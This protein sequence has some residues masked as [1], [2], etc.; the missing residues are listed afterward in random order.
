MLIGFIYRSAK[1]CHVRTE[2][3][4]DVERLI[5]TWK[6]TLVASWSGLLYVLTKYTPVIW[7]SKSQAVEITAKQS[8]SCVENTPTSREWES[9][10]P[11]PTTSLLVRKRLATKVWHER[12]N[13]SLV[14]IVNEGRKVTRPAK[15]KPLRQ[16][17]WLSGVRSCALFSADV[18]WRRPRHHK[19]SVPVR[20]LT[21]GRAP[22]R[23]STF[24]ASDVSGRHS[25]GRS[26]R[27]WPMIR[28]C[29]WITSVTFYCHRVRLFVL[30]AA[31]Y[32]RLLCS[33]DLGAGYSP[34]VSWLLPTTVPKS[35]FCA[36]HLCVVHVFGIKKVLFA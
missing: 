4:H 33:Q 8:S 24:H 25:A 31:N 35:G 28:C 22:G 9:S 12:V 27:C 1:Y 32:C 23:D 13:I 18:R 26:A 10:P 17:P 15:G 2:R 36:F 16:P 34:A 5:G 3:R 6:A 21:A 7:L 29:C 20:Q 19:L 30:I 14:V 11:P